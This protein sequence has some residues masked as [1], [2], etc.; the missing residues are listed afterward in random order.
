MTQHPGI[1][2]YNNKLGLQFAISAIKAQP[3][4]YLR[5]GARDVMLVFLGN[6]RPQTHA[7]MNFTV[8]PHIA[9]LPPFYAQDEY[10]YAGIRSNT[11]PV[12]PY[13]YFMFLYQMPVYFPGIVFLPSW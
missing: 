8:Q 13:A 7:T 11:H 5:V 10:E 6:D 12:Q 2:A 4:E 9:R 1:N 3:L